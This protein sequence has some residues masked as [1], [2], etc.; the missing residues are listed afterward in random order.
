MQVANAQQGTS[1]NFIS[2]KDKLLGAQLQTMFMGETVTTS[3]VHLQT[4]NQQ[5]KKQNVLCV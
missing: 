5:L 3:T 2:N 1:V 4:W